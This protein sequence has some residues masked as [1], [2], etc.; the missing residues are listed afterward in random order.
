VTSTST[1]SVGRPLWREDVSTIC[2]VITQLYEPRKTRN[3]TL[4]SH[5]RLRQPG[6]PGSRIYIPQKQGGLVIPPGT[7]FPL[8]LLLRLAPYDSQGYGGGILTLSPLHRRLCRHQSRSRQYSKPLY[9]LHFRGYSRRPMRGIYRLCHRVLLRCKFM[10]YRFHKD[11]LSHLIINRVIYR[12]ADSME[13][14]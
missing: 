5:L 1:V 7:G 3:H 10:Y 11:L 2:S 12:H 8:C 14:A 6:G 4:L 13:I 9:R